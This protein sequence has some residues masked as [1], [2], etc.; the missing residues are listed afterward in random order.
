MA[1]GT[2]QQVN[3]DAVLA[4]IRQ[5][6]SGGNYTVV[7]K[8]GSDA[9]G[10]Y[11]YVTSTWQAMLYRTIK[12]GWLPQNT[13]LYSR[14]C[15]A[16]PNVQDTVARYDVTTFLGSVGNNVS[17]VPIHW[18]YPAAIASWP[19]M[20]N[21]VPPGNHISLGAYQNKWMS[22]YQSKA[23]PGSGGS[24]GPSNQGN[25]QVNNN[26]GIKYNYAQLEEIWILAGGNP[27]VA[28]V[29]AAV[30][31]AESGGNPNA[32]SS[33]NDYG[34]WQINS[35]HGAMASLDV[36]TNARAAV[37][38]SNNGQDW[39]PWCTCWTNPQA[40]CGHY[41]GAQPQPGSP[42]SRA[43]QPNIPPDTNTPINATAAATGTASG[44]QPGGQQAQE[45]SFL[46]LGGGPCNTV[47]WFISPGGCAAGK[48]VT[49][50]ASDIASGVVNLVMSAILNP[51]I[52]IIA[53][54]FGMVAGGLLML[55]AL[56]MMIK[57]TKAG[58]GIINVG[59]GAAGPEAQQF[60]MPK[61]KEQQQAAGKKVRTMVSSKR[62]QQKQKRE[63]LRNQS[64]RYE[65]GG[66]SAGDSAAGA[67]EGA[68]EAGAAAV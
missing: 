10:A 22:V 54:A 51:L 23:G 63:A 38:I 52:S 11:Q 35:V 44:Q 53:G 17:M 30:A 40:Y 31:T 4:T 50:G 2:A 68:A 29:A 27:Q 56:W 39:G 3:I 62:G 61:T 34:L 67:A 48:A 18:Y 21:Y 47:E 41:L 12:A 55:I 49:G 37:A 13:P 16:P 28:P 5:M 8:G 1:I 9:C 15:Q 57:D 64:R 45:E 65:K 33:S 19:A 36:M 42:A 32:V 66:S 14:A 58:Q 43:F 26:T 7:T 25:A 60:A 24:N 46:G 59:I 6:E 20:A